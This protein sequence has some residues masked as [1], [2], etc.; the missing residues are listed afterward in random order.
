[1]DEGRSSSEAP[2]HAQMIGT[3]SKTGESSS[4]GSSEEEDTLFSDELGRDRTL[5]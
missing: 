1:M 3:R 4:E 2:Q 5:T